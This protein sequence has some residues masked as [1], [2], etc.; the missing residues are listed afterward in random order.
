MAT[1]KTTTAKARP[2]AKKASASKRATAASVAPKQT[3]RIVRPIPA[4][5]T[6]NC[7]LLRL[8]HPDHGERHVYSTPGAM[9][10]CVEA[11]MKRARSDVGPGAIFVA[12]DL[13]LTT[14]EE[15]DEG[16]VNDVKEF[17]K[18]KIG[19]A[20]WRP[21]PEAAADMAE[22]VLDNDDCWPWAFELKLDEKALIRRLEAHRALQAPWLAEDEEMTATVY[23]PTEQ[24]TL[25][26]GSFKADGVTALRSPV[27]LARAKGC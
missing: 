26:Q 22:L 6:R 14:I 16:A 24:L 5:E 23:R 7:Y 11:M 20:R 4:G 1:S 3:R 15:G 13:V 17:L 21:Y 18:V 9:I 8:H 12:S 19:G 10:L 2:A 27:R 25:R